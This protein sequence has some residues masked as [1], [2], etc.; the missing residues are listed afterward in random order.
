MKQ[1]QIYFIFIF[2][3]FIFSCEEEKNE[4]ST[5][6]IIFESPLV[7]SFLIGE[8]INISIFI[9]HDEVIDNI[10]YYEIFDCS[11]D[12]FDSLVLQ[13]WENIYENEWTFNKV[14]GT[15]NLPENTLC[16]CV[17]Q[18]EAT[19]L[20]NVMSQTEIIFDISN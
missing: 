12:D 14:I 20:N 2:S 10:K 19:D 15:T 1:L 17:I 16:S 5:P 7:E 18:I 9:N 4:V 6:N 3:F 11:N 13:E 8:D